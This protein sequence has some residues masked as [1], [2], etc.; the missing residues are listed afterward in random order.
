MAT[1]IWVKIG[2]GHGLLP[3]GTKPVDFIIIGAVWH[4][5]ISQEVLMN[6]FRN[7]CYEMKLLKLLPH[8]PET[9]EL[10]MSFDSYIHLIT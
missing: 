3:D 5:Q 2:S 4:S 8:F 9:N 1:L 6:F 10:L 7:M